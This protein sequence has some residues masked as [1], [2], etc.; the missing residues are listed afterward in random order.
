[1]RSPPRYTG[2]VKAVLGGTLLLAACTSAAPTDPNLPTGDVFAS[3]VCITSN[4]PWPYLVSTADSLFW[5]SPCDATIRKAS[6]VDGSVHA[7]VSNEPHAL[8][9]AA[10]ESNVYWAR[11]DR[12]SFCG[13]LVRASQSDGVPVVLASAQDEMYPDLPQQ[14]VIDDTNVYRS[15]FFDILSVP[16]DGSAPQQVVA[17][18]NSGPFL[19]VDADYIY[20][21]SLSSIHRQRKGTN[22]DEELAVTS[23]IWNPLALT[24]HAAFFWSSQDRQLYRIDKSTGGPATPV[25]EDWPMNRAFIS[26]RVANLYWQSEAASA[27]VRAS[28]D[29]TVTPIAKLDGS[30]E[31]LAVDDEFI[32]WIENSSIYYARR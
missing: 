20:W 11:F 10:D 19:G 13:E 30:A 1:M 9:L 31:A 22:L 29:G 24:T 15:K 4:N 25:L 28:E 2:V 26:D 18:G 7:L 14:L 27:L 3:D 6:K 17:R 8:M 16:K 5:I 32:Y 12:S 21:A 23:T